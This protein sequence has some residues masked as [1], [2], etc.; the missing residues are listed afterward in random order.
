LAR[1]A[2]R[3]KEDKTESFSSVLTQKYTLL[4]AGFKRRTKFHEHVP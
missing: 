3:S 2:Q 4:C 1:T